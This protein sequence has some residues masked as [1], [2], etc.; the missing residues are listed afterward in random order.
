MKKIFALSLLLILGIVPLLAAECGDINNDGKADI[1]D[2]LLCAQYYVGLEP[3]GIYTEMADVNGDSNI[4]IV[5]ALLIAQFYVGLIDELEGCS[6]SNPTPLTPTDPPPTPIAIDLT[7]AVNCGGPAYTAAD[8]TKFTADSGFSGGSTTT[9]SKSIS[10]TSDD[11]LYQSERYGDSSYTFEVPNGVFEI[12]FHF[13]ENYHSSSGSRSFDVT[14]E[15]EQVIN[16]LDIYSEAGASTALVETISQV[17]VKDGELNIKFI[18]ENENALIN[19]IKISATALSGEPVASFTIEPSR[20]KPGEAVSFDASKSFDR[21]G[22]IRSY[23]WSFGD[24]ASGTGV[25]AT[26]TYPEGTYDVTLTVTDNEGKTGSKTTSIKVSEASNSGSAED[27]GLDIQVGSPNGSNGGSSNKLPDPFTMWNGSQVKDMEDWRIRRREL[28]VE[29]EKRI[30]GAKAPPP[31]TIGGTVSG[32]VSSSSYTVT[33]NNPGG[34]TSFSDS[35]KLPTSGSAPYPAIIVVGGMNSLSSTLLNS[36]GIATI[37]Y[38]AYKIASEASGNFTTGKYYD[39][40]PDYRG[41]TGA[42]VAW[43]W[44][45]SRIIDMLEK[46]P[47]VIDPSK[48]AIHGCSRFGKAAFVIGAFDERIALGLPYEPG[49]GGAAPLR[50]LPSLG[51]QSLS[52]CIGEASWFGPTAGSYSSSMA[53]DMSDVAAM[54]APRG[55]LLMDNPHIDHLSYKANYL[56]MAAAYEVYKAMGQSGA[57]WYLGNTGNGNHCSTRSEYEAAQRAMIRRFLKGQN[58]ETKGGLDKHSNHGNIDVAGWTSTWKK[59]SISQ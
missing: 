14:I 42:L 8:G 32:S 55:V 26:H 35:I 29:I 4:N 49:T 3:T 13:A 46:N 48:I 1:V 15:D 7:I 28:V 51:G 21:D 59:G 56:G 22:S 33:V 52:G 53:V 34:S 16:N 20:P 18:T 23:S 30:L 27:S 5:D 45:V 36:E 58:V 57:L 17:E 43:A 38:D 6:G 2:A 44:G 50:S 39:A 11:T 47:G 31:A 54:Y 19:A 24:G 9:N 41:K 25:K 40:N 12:S 10:N 37:N